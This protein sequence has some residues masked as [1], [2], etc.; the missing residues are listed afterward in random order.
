[1][2]TDLDAGSSEIIRAIAASHLSFKYDDL[3]KAT[4]DFN[5]KNRLGEGGYGAVYKVI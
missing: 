3:R 5:Q 1:L 2:I 4:E